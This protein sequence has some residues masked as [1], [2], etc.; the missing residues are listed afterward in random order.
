M[1]SDHFTRIDDEF[2]DVVVPA[3]EGRIKSS[4]IAVYTYLQRCRGTDNRCWP[5][6]KSIG[7]H[8][9]MDR[10]TAMAS[11]RRLEEFGLVTVEERTDQDGNQES[12]MYHIRP[13]AEVMHDLGLAAARSEQARSEPASADRPVEDADEF[14]DL[15]RRLARKSGIP[16]DAM[17]DQFWRVWRSARTAMRKKLDGTPYGDHDIERALVALYRANYSFEAPKLM[18]GDL[19]LAI[20]GKLQKRYRKDSRPHLYFPE[21]D[22]RPSG[23][24]YESLIPPEENVTLEDILAMGSDDGGRSFENRWAQ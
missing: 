17:G 21:Y 11:V 19:L 10:K 23:Q 24:P 6:Y 1:S 18:V 14:T 9:A 20:G 4:D 22:A 13:I 16:E 5:S 2:Y 12:N 7:R 15:V 8:A 3:L